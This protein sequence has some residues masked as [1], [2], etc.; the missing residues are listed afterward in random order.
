MTTLTG[1]PEELLV[2]VMHS[3]IAKVS[4]YVIK[5]YGVEFDVTAKHSFSLTRRTSRGGMKKMKP[6]INLALRHY[7]QAVV[8]NG[9]A[10]LTEY[11]SYAYRNDIGSIHAEWQNTLMGLVAHELAHAIQHYCSGEVV[12]KTLCLSDDIAIE[13]GHGEYFKAIYRDLREVF[14]NDISHIVPYRV[15]SAAE[16]EKVAPKKQK[17]TGLRM[18]LTKSKNGWFIHKYYDAATDKHLGTMA[19]KPGR[20]SQGLKED[21]KFAVLYHPKNGGFFDTHPEARK[22]FIGK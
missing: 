2:Q 13:R 3:H 11:A 5:K 14:V 7:V 18:D 1:S 17:K 21:G 6:Y 16:Q 15:I 10:T 20:A 8:S 4:K 9:K 22:F 19:S 12:V